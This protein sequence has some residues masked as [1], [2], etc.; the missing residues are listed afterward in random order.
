VGVAGVVLRDTKPKRAFVPALQIDPQIAVAENRVA[1][2]GSV[3]D[4]KSQSDSSGGVAGNDVVQNLGVR[5]DC[6]KDPV[7]VSHGIGSPRDVGADE[8][9]LNT[10]AR[11]QSASARDTDAGSTESRNDVARVRRRAVRSVQWATADGVGVA[12]DP[13]SVQGDA[14]CLCPGGVGADEV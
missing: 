8:V 12:V 13:D 5:G 3:G 11:K 7:A 14:Q 1:K 10:S 4:T 2:D 6:G 9:V